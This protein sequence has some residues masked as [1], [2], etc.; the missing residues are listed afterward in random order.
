M[1]VKIEQ[2]DPNLKTSDNT[3][4]KFRA[5]IYIYFKQEKP[6]LKNLVK[7]G[8]KFIYK[9]TKLC[10]ESLPKEDQGDSHNT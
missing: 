2:I 6:N 7:S 3:K 5:E 4:T 8:F 9:Q 10:P 1:I